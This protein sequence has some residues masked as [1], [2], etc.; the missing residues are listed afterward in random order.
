MVWTA[1]QYKTAAGGFLQPAIIGMS[2]HATWARGL[3]L[4]SGHWQSCVF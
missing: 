4:Y 3:L 1:N 2:L